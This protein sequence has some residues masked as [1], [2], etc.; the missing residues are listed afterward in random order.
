MDVVY[1]LCKFDFESCNA[2][3]KVRLLDQILSYLNEGV[4][5]D[6]FSVIG[7]VIVSDFV[8]IIHRD[9]I[10]PNVLVSNFRLIRSDL[11]I[12]KWFNS[13]SQASS[14]QQNGGL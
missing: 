11:P 12:S 10:P 13:L 5:F 14:C 6:N 9:T 4:I 1:E 3:K 8:G 2:D 7:N